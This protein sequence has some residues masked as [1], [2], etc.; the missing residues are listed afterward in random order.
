MKYEVRASAGISWRN[1]RQ[2]IMERQ[3]V[4][5]AEI[6]KGT[7]DSIHTVVGENGKI[8][9]QGRVINPFVVAGRDVCIELLAKNHSNLRV[10]VFSTYIVMISF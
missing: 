7:S 5:V 8:W 10:G 1:E 4:K 6:P 9:V 2:R 3:E